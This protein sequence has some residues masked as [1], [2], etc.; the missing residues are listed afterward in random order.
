MWVTYKSWSL[1]AEVLNQQTGKKLLTNK[2]EQQNTASNWSLGKTCNVELI[3]FLISAEII[4][5]SVWSHEHLKKPEHCVT[6][7]V[8][9]ASPS[10][11]YTK[12]SVLF[13]WSRFWEITVHR[14]QRPL[15]WDMK[16][17]KPLQEPV[18][19]SLSI[20]CAQLS[21]LWGLKLLCWCLLFEEYRGVWLSFFFSLSN[22][23]SFSYI[24]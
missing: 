4:S 6:N 7:S 20:S 14:K 18:E 11:S 3:I 5:G 23:Y 1:Y 19:M 8:V 22:Y 13:F 24:L 2:L 21:L 12:E 9:A 15:Q 10:S 17:F 16:R